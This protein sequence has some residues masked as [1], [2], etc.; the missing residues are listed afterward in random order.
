[1]ELRSLKLDSEYQIYDLM[2]FYSSY[3]YIRLI[4]KE[5]YEIAL[6]TKKVY[7]LPIIKL[8][9]RERQIIFYRWWRLEFYCFIGAKL[10]AKK[11]LEYNFKSSAILKM[12]SFFFRCVL[13]VINCY[14]SHGLM[15]CQIPSV[16]WYSVSCH[17]VRLTVRKVVDSY[18][19]TNR[20]R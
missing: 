11:H 2:W 9:S 7:C 10:Q 16:S 5:K 3:A 19:I 12:D 18:H 4:I 17:G 15:F 1:M 13:Y 20:L 14:E 6:I 8:S